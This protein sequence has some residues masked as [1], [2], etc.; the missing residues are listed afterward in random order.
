LTVLILVA[1]TSLAFIVDADI[2]EPVIFEPLMIDPDILHVA[3]KL[4]PVTVWVVFI[5]PVAITLPV[6]TLAGE[7]FVA[8]RFVVF[9]LVAITSV[10]LTVEP[11]IFHRDLILPDTMICPGDTT[12]VS[13]PT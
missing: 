12:P 13:L 8:V 3:T 9:T 7:K 1:I 2:P 5:L 11:V 4:A 10:A 6:E